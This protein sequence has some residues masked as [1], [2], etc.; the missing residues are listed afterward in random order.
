MA[1]EDSDYLFKSKFQLGLLSSVHDDVV[2]V[3]L[4]D[5]RVGKTNVLS[6]FTNNEFRLDSRT[7]IGVEFSARTLEI[8]GHMVR[9]TVSLD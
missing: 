7:T 2:V 4:G 6:K 3:M 1:K 8:D 5:P 9:G